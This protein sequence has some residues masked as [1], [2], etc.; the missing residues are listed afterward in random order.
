MEMNKVQVSICNKE[1]TI[2]GTSS[3]EQIQ[4]AAEKV[5]SMIGEMKAAK[6]QFSTY[7]LALLA[8]VNISNDYLSER[9]RADSLVENVSNLEEKVDEYRT[10]WENA[11]EAF[12]QHRKDSEENAEKISHLKDIFNK[13]SADL[14][15][16]RKESKKQ[17]AESENLKRENSK[18]QSQ[19]EKLKNRLAAAE[20]KNAAAAAD[21][22]ENINKYKELESSFY[23]IQMENLKLKSDLDEAL[24]MLE[25]ANAPEDPIGLID[26]ALGDSDV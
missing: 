18:L 19:L 25:E 14:T 9:Q 21:K 10:M 20:K 26:E 17:A 3:E 15:A 23:D 12:R 16:L 8:A 1:Y 7:T 6:P 13:K 24:G 4:Q 5:D 2:A 11:K 22:N